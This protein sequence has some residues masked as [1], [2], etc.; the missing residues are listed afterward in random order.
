MLSVITIEESDRW[1][2][3][4]KG[5]SDYDVYYLSDYVRAFQIHG[6]GEPVLFYYEGDNYR[7]VN[8]VMLRDISKDANFIDQI[9]V[10]S[11]FDIT[12]PYG[13]GGFLVDG[14]F[15]VRNLESLEFEFKKYCREN[16]IISEFVR[17]HPV[18][19]NSSNVSSIYDVIDV[20]K[21]ITINLQSRNQIWADLKGKNRNVIRK[22]KNSGVEIYWGRNPNLFEEFIDMYNATMDKDNA[23]DYY[24]FNKE[25]YKSIVNDLKYNALMFYAVLEGKIIA[26]SMIL[27]SNRTMHY[28]LSASYKEYL[29]YA[30][31]NLLLYE[32]ACWGCENGF[33]NFHLGGGLGGKQDSLFKFKEAF[34]KNSNTYFSIGEKI[35]DKVKYD[36]LLKI[37]NRENGFSRNTTFFPAYRDN[38]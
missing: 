10:N 3:I 31:T 37:R 26:M 35:F 18:I 12:T 2:N 33:N 7:A 4:V 34:N 27:F 24:Y 5:F 6:D 25:F 21:T 28:H 11:Y 30:P 29:A 9:P 36:E 1:D 38:I 19:D 8:V 22:A 15:S 14:S 16:N 13:Y 17:F 32:A 23:K 20:G